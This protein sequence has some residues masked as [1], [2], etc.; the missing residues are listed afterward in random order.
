MPDLIVDGF[1]INDNDIADHIN[2]TDFLLVPGCTTL[3]V[4]HYP[5]LQSIIEKIKVP[6]FNLGA[7]FFGQP[8]IDSLANIKKFHQPVGVRDPESETFLKTNNIPTKFIGCPTLFS[9][10]AE[11]F[12]NRPTKK[13]VFI[14]GLQKIEEQK[15]L[16][17]E[18]IKNKFDV[19]VLIQEETQ[20]TLIKEFNLD[21]II[22]SPENLINSLQDARLIITG[23]LHGALPA[24]ACGTPV[25]FIQTI[26]DSRFSLLRY[27]EVDF[28][29]F[30]DKL[31]K[32]KLFHQ[33]ESLD[34]IK[35]KQTFNKV[36]ILRSAFSNYIAD[37]VKEIS[38][39][40]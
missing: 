15:N 2:Q 34:F 32:N 23:R 35:S 10:S 11:K 6:I 33:I 22:Y 12:E 24:I 7:A 3:T 16:L 20:K 8:D 29:S 28:F 25:F 13:I 4:K 31:L 18:L 36:K 40:N 27:L 39:L 14:F 1:K 30:D 17:Q 9:G 38:N 21:P 5:G 26:C 37:F 19:Q